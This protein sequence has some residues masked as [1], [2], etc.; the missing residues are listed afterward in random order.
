MEF[1]RQAELASI[2]IKQTSSSS[3]L[4]TYFAFYNQ[5]RPHTALDDKSSD[6]ASD[7]EPRLLNC[8]TVS[9][10]TVLSTAM[11]YRREIDGLRALAVVPV[12][13]FT[14]AFKPLVAALL[15]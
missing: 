9:W 1:E 5:R 13:F 8:S 3:G 4:D 11:T 2:G 6:A 10:V 15:V 7:L 12:I 14:L